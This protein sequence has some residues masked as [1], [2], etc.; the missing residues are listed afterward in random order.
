MTAADT[1]L[2]LL[3]SVAVVAAAIAL[4]VAGDRHFSNRK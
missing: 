2:T 3:A 4:L 1:L